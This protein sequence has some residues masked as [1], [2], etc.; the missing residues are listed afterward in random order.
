MKALL[1]TTLAAAAGYTATAQVAKTTILEHFT[2]SNCG[3]CAS[4]NPGAYTTLGNFPNALHITFHPSSPYATCFF[5]M[6]NAVEN[7]A[8]TN[9]YGIYGSTPRFV[10]NGVAISSVAQL[11]NTLASAQTDSSDFAVRATQEFITADSVAVRVVVTKVAADTTTGATLFVGALQ[12]TVVKATGNGESIHQDVFR[13][14]LSTSIGNVIALPTN[15]GDS[16]VY[17][18]SYVVNT[19]WIAAKMN[20]IAILQNTTSKRNIN[21]AQSINVVTPVTPPAALSYASQGSVVVYPNPANSVIHVQN[22]NNYSSYTIYATDGRQAIASGKMLFSLPVGN[23]APGN[24]I[25]LLTSNTGTVRQN[26]SIAR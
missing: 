20:T 2:N 6:Q 15:V 1:L 17:T 22:W 26:I 19:T 21:A 3:I 18:Y 25:L 13:K 11:N 8:R 14:A 4:V 7:D 10:V 9:Y 5:S 12:D 23:L 24:Y 16:V